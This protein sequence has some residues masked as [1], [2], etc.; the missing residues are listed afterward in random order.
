MLSPVT[1]LFGMMLYFV[2]LWLRAGEL[3]LRILNSMGLE[4]VSSRHLIIPDWGV[5]VSR[6]L[7]IEAI[8]TL[9]IAPT[10]CN[11]PVSPLLS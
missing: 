1:F 6:G 5:W 10:A 11:G 2:G 8:L 3:T 4:L 7:M 9:R